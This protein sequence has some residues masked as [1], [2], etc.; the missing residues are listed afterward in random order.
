[1]PAAPLPFENDIHELEQ[2][3]AKL[4]AGAGTG[5]SHLEEIRRIRRELA[6]LKKKRYSNLTAW[7]TVLVSRHPDRPQTMDY[8][9]LLFEDYVELH[10]DR[11]F[12]DDRAMRCGFTRIGDSKLV[13]IGHQKGHT[14]RERQECYYGCR[15]PRRLPESSEQNEA[16]RE[17]SFAH[18]LFDRHAWSISR[19]RC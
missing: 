10:G 17:V 6:S 7:E 1:M 12:G 11:A 8:V 16:G 15:A 4:E 3:L 9:D 18:H 19:N 2:I 14:L 13:L 5:I